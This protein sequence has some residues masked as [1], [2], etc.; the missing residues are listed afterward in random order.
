[1]VGARFFLLQ[2]LNIDLDV[3]LDHVRS[4]GN[5]LQPSHG[6]TDGLCAGTWARDETASSHIRHHIA[7]FPW[8]TMSAIAVPGKRHHG[9]ATGERLQ[10]HSG[11]ALRRHHSGCRRAY[12]PPKSSSC[13]RS[14]RTNTSG[15]APDQGV[16]PRSLQ[17]RPDPV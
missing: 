7:G 12:A 5:T 17:N 8:H 9:C 15:G 6:S 1:M 4:W 16:A 3:R 11:A 2:E 10:W 14:H 13:A